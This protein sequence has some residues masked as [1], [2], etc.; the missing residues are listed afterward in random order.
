MVTKEGIRPIEE[1]LA[2]AEAQKEAQKET[3]KV[4]G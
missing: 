3:E 2:E 4:R 1:V